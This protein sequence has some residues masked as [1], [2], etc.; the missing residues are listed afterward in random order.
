MEFNR[1]MAVIF[2]FLAFLVGLAMTILALYLAKPVEIGFFILMLIGLGG[3]FWGVKELRKKQMTPLGKKIVPEMKIKSTAKE[4]A[5]SGLLYATLI[6]PAIAFLAILFVYFFYGKK[7][8]FMKFHAGESGLL[9]ILRVVL[10][11]I[12][13]FIDPTYRG[14]EGFYVP[15]N[16]AVV[17][18]S[19]ILGFL[20]IAMLIS[21]LFGKCFKLSGI[22][23]FLK[24]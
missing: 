23:D 21:A 18:P 10:L 15:T 8:K 13:P 19:A 3:F 16:P 22:F 5:I 17:L 20:T 24:K 12:I 7:S 2:G 6:I 14:V 1:M 11:L 9:W 4:R